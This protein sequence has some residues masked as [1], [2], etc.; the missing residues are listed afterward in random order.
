MSG[1]APQVTEIVA[2][3]TQLERLFA[4]EEAAWAERMDLKALRRFR[5]ALD[6]AHDRLHQHL[7]APLPEDAT[8]DA[9]LL[10]SARSL[11][12]ETMVAARL[13]LAGC[14]VEHEVETPSGKHVDF[15]A[16]RDGLTIHVHVKRAPQ[17]TFRAVRGAVPRAWRTLENAGRGLVIALFLWKNLRG[18]ALQAALKDAFDF[19]EQ[20]SVGDELLLREPRT[21]RTARIKS[22]LHETAPC[23]RLRIAGPSA[24]GHAEVVADVEEHMDRHVPRFQATLRKAFSQFMPRSE[25]IIV[26]CGNH[27]GFEA[28]A[29]AL[30]GSRIERW[31]RRPRVGS[32]IAYG[33]GGDGFW[34]GSM[35]N[36][37]R[38]AVYWPL[39]LGAAPLLF[40]RQPVQARS[41]SR[42]DTQEKTAQLVQSI[43]A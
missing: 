9:H 21:A 18:A 36:Q 27:I 42:H 41:A 33:R 7:R 24:S 25:N 10:D 31:D 19:V 30:L 17:E 38:M 12:A 22:G 13:L 43:F 16:R 14:A 15:Q 23:A 8:S 29:T 40:V 4:R 1:R 32:Y 35:R 34:A 28:F 37:S 6:E 3:L 5:R 11:C 26:V 39:D 2:L 20:A